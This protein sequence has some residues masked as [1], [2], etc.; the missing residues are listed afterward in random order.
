MGK[1]KLS[2]IVFIFSVLSLLISIK[3]FWNLAIFA[4][5][6]NSSPSIVVGGEF[7]LIM[8]WLRLLL[9]LLLCVIS[10][11]SIFKGKKNK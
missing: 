7:W 1:R 8:D 6:Y 11:I 10:G 9:L 4:D 5:E 2:I 3:L